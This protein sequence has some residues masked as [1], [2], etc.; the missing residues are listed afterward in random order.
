MLLETLANLKNRVYDFLTSPKVVIRS[1]F[2]ASGIFLPAV[3][4]GVIVAQ[5]DP[6]GYNMIDNFISDMGSFNHTP[7][8][9]F[10]DYGAMLTCFFMIPLGFYIDKVLAPLP[11]NL[12]E[13][14]ESSRFRLRLGSYGLMFFLIGLIGFFGIGLFSED[15]SGLLKPWGLPGL[16]GPFSYVVFGG[17]AFAGLF[18]GFLIVLYRTLIPKALGVYMMFI[19]PIPGVL[20]I[21]GADP[22]RPFWEWMLLFSLFL[23]IIPVGLLIIIHAKEELKNYRK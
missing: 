21:L 16:H 3:I 12:N 18:F 17:L 8:P 22:S 5:F 13:P 10:L 14:R 15:R 19:P 9:Y 7:L 2:I 23:W 20:F 1:T 6:D 11:R 4:I